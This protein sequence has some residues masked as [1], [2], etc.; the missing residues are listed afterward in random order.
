VLRISPPVDSATEDLKA[1]AE[2]LAEAT[3]L[4]P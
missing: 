1:F 4:P 3:E 2:A